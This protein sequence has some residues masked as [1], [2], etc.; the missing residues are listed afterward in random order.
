M[1]ITPLPPAE[2]SQGGFKTWVSSQRK[3]LALT[4]Q[5]SVALNINPLVSPST[6]D[7]AARGLSLTLIRP[8]NPRF[9][10]KR[11]SNAVIAAER[12][13]YRRAARQ[14]SLLDNDLDA[15]EPT[16]YTFAFSFDD[17][18]GRHMHS[19]GDWETQAA[20]WK[21]SKKYNEAKALEHLSQTYNDD[22]PS[23][24]MVFAMGTVKARPRQWLLLGVIRLNVLSDTQKRQ[25]TFQF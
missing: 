8:Q 4:G 5:F 18:A 7:A 10:F 15:L 25:A 11:K 22:Y 1:S 13:G 21:L 14:G 17:A 16:P 12:E 23:K 3:F 20:Y 6:A 9:R 24:G 19:C 2:N